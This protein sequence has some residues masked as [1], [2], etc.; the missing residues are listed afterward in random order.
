[1][2]VG[3][4]NIQEWTTFTLRCQKELFDV[5]DFETHEDERREV[6]IKL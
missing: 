3:L 4:Q 5:T 6:D 1:M 2:I